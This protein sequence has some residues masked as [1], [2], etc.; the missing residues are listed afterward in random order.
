MAAIAAHPAHHAH[1]A[2]HQSLCIAIAT[3]IGPRPRLFCTASLGSS[4]GGISGFS[5]SCHSSTF[6]ACSCGLGRF[7]SSAGRTL[8]RALFT[9]A[10]SS[11]G[12]CGPKCSQI[13]PLGIEATDQVAGNG[14]IGTFNPCDWP[15]NYQK[16]WESGNIKSA[17]SVLTKHWRLGLCYDGGSSSPSGYLIIEANGGLNQQRSSI[18]NA[19]AVAGLLNAILVIPRFHFHSVWMDPRQKTTKNYNTLPQSTLDFYLLWIVSALNFWSPFGSITLSEKYKFRDIY[20]EDHFIRTLEGHVTVVRKLPETLMKKFDYNISNIPNFRVKAWAPASH[21]LEV[22]YPLLREH[23]VIQLSPFA[24][25]L[26]MEVPSNIQS[27]RCLANYEALK[28]SVPIATLAKQLVDRMTRKSSRTDGK[29][30]SV[31]LR[32]EK[33]MV[34]FSCC[35]Y[36]GGETEKK[37][38]ESA[39]ERGWKGKFSRKGRIIRPGLNRVKGRCPL[40]PLEV[41]EKM[42]FST[43]SFSLNESFLFQF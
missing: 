16:A 3:S 24:N 21:Y 27:L 30:V 40:T 7:P 12:I 9:G 5:S 28:F 34:A 35:E 19:V 15:Q 42:F 41:N 11:S 32:F 29:Y 33:D 39:R 31:H 20:D 14:V 38:M 22:I 37:E 26:S 1:P 13:M 10:A 8:S 18:C 36:D 4:S 25:R 17:I 43:F 6:P 2:N 23:G